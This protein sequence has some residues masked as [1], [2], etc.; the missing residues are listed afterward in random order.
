MSNTLRPKLGVDALW[1]LAGKK[2]LVRVDFNVPIKKGVIQNDYRIRSA[3]PTIRKIVDQGGQCIVM[4]HMGRPTGVPMPEGASVEKH[5][6]LMQTWAAEKGAG[7]SVFFAVLPRED[8]KWILNRV[9]KSTY[10]AHW[11]G[12]VP[13]EKDTGKTH[14]FA[15]L[16]EDVKTDLL[17]QWKAERARSSSDFDHLRKYHGYDQEVTLEPVAAKL[18]ELL[19][20]KVAFA[21]DCLH[22][23]DDVAAMKNGDVL[24]LE[25]VRFYKEENSKKEDDR[26]KMAKALAAYGDYY[27]CDAFGTAHRDAA[28]ITGIPKI[29]GH[30]VAGYLM[31]KEIDC[32][33]KALTNP[34][35]PMAAIVGGSKVTDKI[36]VLENLVKK[37]NKLF[38]GGAMA[39]V[40]LKAQGYNIG[41]SF[42]ESGSSFNS[43]YGAKEKNPEELALDLMKSAKE[44][45]VELFLPTDHVCHTEFSATD[46]PLTT[47]D[48]NI[49]DGY[50]ALDIGPK[51]R[52][53]Y[54]QHIASCKTVVWNGPMG[55]FE[56]P[57]Y[58]MGT[59]DVAKALAECDGMTIIGGGDSAS[60]AELSGYA[61]QITH[62]STGGGASLE[63]L[64]GKQLP[65]IA[66][67]S[68]LPQDEANAE[69]EKIKASS[70][71]ELTA[72]IKALK[73]Q[74]LN[75]QATQGGFDLG[76][77]LP[78]AALNAALVGMV[79]Y[80][81][82]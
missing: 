72:E 10:P 34:A 59:F 80:L 56:I 31:K 55:V 52:A 68:D 82:K 73:E 49:P 28:T 6:Y 41:R 69:P 38:I 8:K 42:C 51:T 25:N 47:D 15:G 27:V 2:V 32:F 54:C 3:L 37:V 7:K 30:G 14:F 18:A 66:V 40:F 71:D 58:A 12:T 33:A 77:E 16:A 53:E 48:Q 17:N 1:P 61:S 63:L 74:V 36:K 39:Y 11:K 13:S 19:G 81:L 65:G 35:R 62:I 29:L 46:S 79:M 57:T 9:D 21:R 44:N 75:Q 5:N 22:A 70:L 78:G 43:K 64:E 20:K 76:R 26:M 23:H 4:S 50:M 45:G 60:A 24:L 67:L